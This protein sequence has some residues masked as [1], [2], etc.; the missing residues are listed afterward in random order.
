MVRKHTKICPV[1]LV[2]TT[3]DLQ[4]ILNQVLGKYKIHAGA[5]I[6][7]ISNSAHTITSFRFFAIDIIKMNLDWK[8]CHHSE[9]HPSRECRGLPLSPSR[10]LRTWGCIQKSS[11]KLLS[12]YIG[13][14]SNFRNFFFFLSVFFF[15]PRKFT[16]QRTAGEGG[17]H[18][19]N[20]SLPLSPAS[21]TLRH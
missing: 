2:P 1:P 6:I 17:G 19:F 4:V 20:S 16:N 18:F 7:I 9:A 11:W 12:S 21:Q 13:L 14:L 10:Y 8:N 5:Y 3:V 15:F